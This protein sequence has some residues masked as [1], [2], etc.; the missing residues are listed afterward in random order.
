MSYTE[1]LRCGG[2]LLVFKDSWQI[3]Y[4]SPGPD[5]RYNNTFV[6]VPELFGKS[7]DEIDEYI[8]AF[9]ENWQELQELKTAFPQGE[10]SKTGKLGMNIRINGYEPGINMQGR[11]VSSL[12]GRNHC[13]PINTQAQ[14]DTVILSYQYVKE[15]VPQI[16]ELLKTQYGK[17]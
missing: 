2:T 17:Q 6:R 13:W 9:K 12:S 14:L 3:L 8:S 11:I 7:I 10:M 5:R 16:Q 1:N 4:C 15:R